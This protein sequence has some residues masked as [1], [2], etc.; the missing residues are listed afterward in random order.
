MSLMDVKAAIVAGFDLGYLWRADNDGY[1]MGLTGELA[2]GED[3]GLYEI[4]AVQTAALEIP[5]PE[6]TNILGNNHFQAAFI[7]PLGESPA[8]NVQCAAYDM[9]LAVNLDGTKVFEI[10]DIAHHV[11]GASSGQIQDVGLLLSASAVAKTAGYKGRFLR[12]GYLCPAVQAVFKGIG[13]FNQR[14]EAP[15]SMALV[16]NES[17][18]FPWGQDMS[19][20][21]HGTV[22]GLMVPWFAWHYT[23]LHTFVGDG[24]TS[25]VTLAKTPAGDH[26]ASPAKVTVYNE[27]TPL[28]PTTDWTLVP[29]TRVL[30]FQAGA[31]PGAGERCEIYYQWK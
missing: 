1:A 24:T 17:D 14:G 2:N 11:L 20:D 26:T 5:D 19:L 21:T 29:A 28:T 3:A 12:F 30:T 25:T 27:G 15:V 6:R 22:G 18:R 7:W 4:L 13:Q 23:M 9:D 31:I 16:V 8:G 10:G